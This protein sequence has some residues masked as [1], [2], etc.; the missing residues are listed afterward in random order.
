MVTCFC[1]VCDEK[2]TT[3]EDNK[4]DVTNYVFLYPGCDI[5]QQ[6]CQNVTTIILFCKVIR[7]NVLVDLESKLLTFF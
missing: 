7:G 6:T 1:N 4:Y 5:M 3:Y 2:I